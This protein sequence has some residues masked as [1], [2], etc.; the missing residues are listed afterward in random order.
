M[1]DI[2]FIKK[3]PKR[4][5]DFLKKRNLSPTSKKLIEIH[6]NYLKFLN[7]KE[8]LQ[9]KRNKL[10]T[11]IGKLSKDSERNDIESI[12]KQVVKIKNDIQELENLSNKKMQE[13]NEILENIPNFLDEKVPYGKS[14]KNNEVLRIGGKI[15]E[16]DFKPV[17]HVTLGE[18]LNLINYSQAS[19][20]SGS[21]FSVLNSELA[22]LN[23]ALI[24]YMLDKHTLNNGYVEYLVPELV[25]SKALFGTGQLP[26]FKAD[27]FQTSNDLWLIPTGEVSLTNLHRESIIS[28]KDLPLRYTTYT[29]CFRSEAGSAGIDTKGLI[30]EHQFGKVELVSITE[31]DKS[32]NELYRMIDCVENILKDLMLPYRIICLCSGDTGFSASITYDFE[33]WMPGQKKFREVSSC[34][35]CKDFQARRMK[36]RV[37]DNK[38]I[39]FPHTLNG[40]GLA[41]GRLIVAIIENYQTKDGHVNI[42]LVLQKYMGGKEIIK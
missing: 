9:Q 32:E 31:P 40:S 28:N 2:K 13:L 6:N 29:N 37:K 34:S 26:K 39:F 42:P 12:K 24:N 20:I 8:T 16:K 36:M 25:K 7:L 23:R 22:Q 18:K 3:E 30:R 19:N 27:L 21:R 11:S 35:N 5:D 15:E 4:F 33:V 41:V 17:D 38:K 1:H 14:D 10:S